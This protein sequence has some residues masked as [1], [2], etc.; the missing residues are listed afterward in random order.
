MDTEQFMRAQDLI[1]ALQKNIFTCIPNQPR[2]DETSV[3]TICQTSIELLSCLKSLPRDDSVATPEFVTSLLTLIISGVDSLKETAIEILATIMSIPPE[4]VN[5]IL[6]KCDPSPPC[7]PDEDI[8]KL[9]PLLPTVEPTL[10]ESVASLIEYSGD[11]FTPEFFSSTMTPFSCLF[12]MSSALDCITTLPNDSPLRSPLVSF[13]ASFGAH[14]RILQYISLDSGLWFHSF[15]SVSFRRVLL[16]LIP[17]LPGHL[18]YSFNKMVNDLCRDLKHAQERY[19]LCLNISEVKRRLPESPPPTQT[20]INKA[21]SYLNKYNTFERKGKLFFYFLTEYV[22]QEDPTDISLI[23]VRAFQKKIQIP[24]H[25]FQ[26]VVFVILRSEY[27]ED[28]E[29]CFLLLSQQNLTN[30]FRPLEPRLFVGLVEKGT[31]LMQ[32]RSTVHVQKS[33]LETFLKWVDWDQLELSFMFPHLLP[34]VSV[35]TEMIAKGKRNLAALTP[36]VEHVVW[37]GISKLWSAHL[38]ESQRRF[39][40]SILVRIGLNMPSVQL[41]GRFVYFFTVNLARPK[42]GREREI[43]NDLGRVMIAEGCEDLFASNSFR[44]LNRTR[45]RA[46]MNRPYRRSALPEE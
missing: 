28:Y 4:T 19:E 42:S 25:L 32:E 11:M 21:R 17:F 1:T 16:N 33:V 31:D 41:I 46:E 43:Q 13:L 23:R 30:K 15:L 27:Y 18:F 40:A 9:Y 7:S 26:E 38:S 34:L 3:A 8:S 36:F 24:Q 6:T 2:F 44:V 14:E 10:A 5:D 45:L 37:K 12:F 22:K 39:F 20:Q 35:T 29:F